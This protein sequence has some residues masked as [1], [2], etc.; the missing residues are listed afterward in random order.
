MNKSTVESAVYHAGN[1][2]IFPTQLF[3][4]LTRYNPLSI[5]F[6]VN[7]KIYL[8]IKSKLVAQKHQ[9]QT[10]QN[11]VKNFSTTKQAAFTLVELLVVI[12]IISLL[13]A[14]TI[15]VLQIC[16]QRA[17]AIVC[18]SNIKQLSLGLFMY[19]ADNER[20]PYGFDDMRMD[21]PPGGYPG[22]ASRDAM[23][24]WWFHY[25]I[26]YNR[27]D[28]G[29]GTVALCPSKRV[30]D[31]KFNYGVLNANYGIN[32]SICKNS[33]GYMVYRQ[34][35]FIGTPLCS[36]DIERPSETLLLF[37]SGYAIITWM[38]AADV[39]PVTLGSRIEDMAYIPGLK[40]NE[41]RVQ[42]QTI[43]PGLEDDAIYGR[44]LNKTINVA[45]ADGHISRIKADNVFVEQSGDGYRN[46][47]PLW[48]PK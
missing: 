3:F 32:C 38:H 25:I 46:R 42:D 31:P 17:K 44:H 1:D 6:T 40:I 36:A 8:L 4:P 34:A 41:Q 24:W 16:R 2:E 23:G 48:L 27:R 7:P 9:N 20:F 15:P 30:K 45:F 29:K 39:L 37:D 18:A 13:L 33:C 11:N 47:S 22:C 19:E 28:R 21:V 14:I 10:G 26:D 43:W 12:A 5:L 35:G